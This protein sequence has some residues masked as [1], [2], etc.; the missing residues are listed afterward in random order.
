MLK[1]YITKQE[2]IKD[3][4]ASCISSVIKYF[5]G[6]VPMEI[7]RQ[8]T[9]T[10]KEGTTAFHIMKALNKYGFDVAGYKIENIEEEMIVLPA[11]AHLVLQNNL[12]HFVVIYKI[13]KVKKTILL[14]DPARGYKTLSIEEFNKLWTNILIIMKPRH[15]IPKYQKPN[16]LFRFFWKLFLEEKKTL[17]KILIISILFMG[18]SISSSFY[19][20][21]VLSNLNNYFYKIVIIF[22]IITILRILLEYIRTKYQN[23]LNKNI[24]EKTIIPFLKHI[25]YLPLEY[26]KSKTTGEIITRIRELNN[27]KNLFS[28]IFVIAI[29]DL[30]LAI[31]A[32]FFIFRMNYKIFLILCLLFIVYFIISFLLKEAIIPPFKTASFWFGSWSG[33]SS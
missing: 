27:I 13:D 17:F 26:V 19:I 6:Y 14:M 31:S 23:I 10:N 22:F 24:D 7:I 29:L 3:C 5:D 9:L 12:H 20:K 30:F 25:F 4:G 2:D 15:K 28:K 16:K 32:M 18:I 1:K 21:L 8:D 33:I 11:I